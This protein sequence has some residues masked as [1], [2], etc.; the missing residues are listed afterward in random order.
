MTMVL[1]RVLMGCLFFF[2]GAWHAESRAEADTEGSTEALRGALLVLKPDDVTVTGGALFPSF[3]IYESA[4]PWVGAEVGW[5]TG[6]HSRVVANLGLG[7]AWV[8][9]STR[10]FA[11]VGLSVQYF[12]WQKGPLFFQF[13]LGAMPYFEHIGLV[14]PERPISTSTFGATLTSKFGVGVRIAD[15]EVMVGSDR[16]VLPMDFYTQFTG[17]ETLTWDDTLM[18]WVGRNIW[19]RSHK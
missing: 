6:P 8:Q 3:L 18:V 15:W 1:K 4:S 17:T 16:N 11:P 7:A 12:P 2:S 10:V 19:R 9:G 14:M 5:Q 13:G